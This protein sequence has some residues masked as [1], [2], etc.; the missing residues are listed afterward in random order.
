MLDDA[1]LDTHL[2]IRGAV[3]GVAGPAGVVQNTVFG[4]GAK[5]VKNV[6]KCVFFTPPRGALIIR[7]IG[8]FCTPPGYLARTSAKLVYTPPPHPPPPGPPPGTPPKHP[9]PTPPKQHP[10]KI[11]FCP[12][13]ETDSTPTKPHVCLNQTMK[14]SGVF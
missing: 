12:S 10:P 6:Q 13:S 14:K 1:T 5:C 3:R 11:Q 4:G 9:P 7:Q 8:C 2:D